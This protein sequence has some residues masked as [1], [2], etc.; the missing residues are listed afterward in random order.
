M[1]PLQK[2]IIQFQEEQLHYGNFYALWLTCKLATNQILS[3]NAFNK[4]SIIYIIGNQ[5][6]QSMETRSKKLVSNVGFDACLYLDPRFHHI[7]DYSQKERAI[8]FL[9]TL[10]EQIKIH[11][12]IVN[13]NNSA[14]SMDMDSGHFKHNNFELLDN[15][16]S[17]S[18]V[19]PHE[20]TNV[21][22]K[23]ET[24]K[25][26]FM[27]SNVNVL[28]FWKDRKSND[29]ELYALSKVCFAIPPTQVSIT[30]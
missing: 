23:I 8:N 15:F 26:P 4:D 17:A 5:L 24:L 19:L 9:K 7:I 3:T 11:G 12:P 1:D 27:K 6:I 21:Y 18:M 22:E 20:S 2:A 16:L 10:W 28:N 13:L 25:L 30:Y 29:P 14:S